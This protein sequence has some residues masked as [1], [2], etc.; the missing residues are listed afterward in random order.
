MRP[1]NPLLAL[2]SALLLAGACAPAPDRPLVLAGAS[3]EPALES[4]HARWTAQGGAPVALG[5]GP[6]GVLARQIAAGAPAAAFFSADPDLVA[7][8]APMRWEGGR[9]GV[10]VIARRADWRECGRVAL[11]D[12]E[13]TPL[14]RYA[15]E[16]LACLGADVSAD[17]LLPVQGAPAVRAAFDAG[18]ADAALVYA[19][20]T[21]RSRAAVR[22]VPPA[23]CAPR[24]R[25][26]A[27]VRDARAAAFVRW[28]VRDTLAWRRAGLDL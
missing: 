25:Y 8:T 3:L 28:A 11:G 26:A 4:A 22:E 27:T 19:A 2:G 21:V 17:R 5:Y 1:S 24:V 15:L 7:P 9:S 16:A 18:H 14:G 10:A 6:S 13:T 20:D 23:A 12:P